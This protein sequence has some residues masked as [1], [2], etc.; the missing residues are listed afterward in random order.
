MSKK[1]GWTSRSGQTCFAA[2]APD[3]WNLVYL[4]EGSDV[5]IEP[6]EMEKILARLRQLANE[7]YQKPD[8]RGYKYFAEDR[9]RD[10]RS[11]VESAKVAHRGLFETIAIYAICGILHCERGEVR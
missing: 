11:N 7:L 10:I 8:F 3:A 5:S 6:L 1:K 2:S 9:L 4:A